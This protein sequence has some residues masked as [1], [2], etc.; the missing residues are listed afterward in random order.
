MPPAFAYELVP[1]RIALA[2]VGQ[3]IINPLPLVRPLQ[4]AEP[5]QDRK[6]DSNFIQANSFHQSS[7][8]MG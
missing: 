2:Y 1:A 5:G 6:V 7:P 4:Q 3:R 8:G